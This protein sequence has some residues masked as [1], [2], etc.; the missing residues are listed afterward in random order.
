MGTAVLREGGM[1]IL[2]PRAVGC[3]VSVVTAEE[4]LPWE[5]EVAQQPGL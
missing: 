2:E 4:D 5:I 3:D 1:G